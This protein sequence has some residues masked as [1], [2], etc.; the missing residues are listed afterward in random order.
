LIIVISVYHKERSR[1]LSFCRDCVSRNNVP[2]QAT[3]VDV[4]AYTTCGISSR[5]CT[6]QESNTKVVSANRILIRNI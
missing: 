1:L 5:E 2:T 4:C 3:V 6:A